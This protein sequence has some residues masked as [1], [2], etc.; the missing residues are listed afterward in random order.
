V[1]GAQ[2]ERDWDALRDAELAGALPGYGQRGT[3]ALQLV[4]DRLDT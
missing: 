4:F 3:G 1:T 2:D